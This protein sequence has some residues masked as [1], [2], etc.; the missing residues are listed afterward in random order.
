MEESRPPAEA[1]RR[2]AEAWIPSALL[3]HLPSSAATSIGTIPGELFSALY[4]PPPY[5]SERA[6]EKLL[7]RVVIP[8]ERD[9]TCPELRTAGHGMTGWLSLVIE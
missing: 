6:S 8:T 4:F 5:G 9:S 1:E 3:P 7:G 2:R